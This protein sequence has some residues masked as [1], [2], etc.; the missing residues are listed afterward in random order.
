VFVVE[1]LSV[2]YPDPTIYFS[3]FQVV[4]ELVLSCAPSVKVPT[5]LNEAAPFL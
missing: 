5:I 1:E 2:V 4:T 3:H